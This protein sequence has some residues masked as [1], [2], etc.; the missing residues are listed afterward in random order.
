MT[1]ENVTVKLRR[2]NESGATG[3][4]NIS[5]VLAQGEPGQA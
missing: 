2:G 3:W 4:A 5:P 1:T